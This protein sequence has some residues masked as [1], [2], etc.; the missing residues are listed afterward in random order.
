[1]KCIQSVVAALECICPRNGCTVRNKYIVLNDF[2]SFY[3]SVSFLRFASKLPMEPHA[4]VLKLIQMK[5]I[6]KI[7]DS[8]CTTTV[9]PMYLGS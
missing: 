7:H 6:C 3:I 8:K 4:K 1:M 2:I 5:F 9:L